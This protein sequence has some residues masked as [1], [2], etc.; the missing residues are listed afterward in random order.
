MQSLIKALGSSPRFS[1]IKEDG[2]HICIEESELCF[3]VDVVVFPYWP[4]Y[5]KCMA[6]FP[7]PCFDVLLCTPCL[8]DNAAKIGK[9]VNIFY[10]VSFYADALC[11]ACVDP[12]AFCFLDVYFKTC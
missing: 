9:M 2:L 5:S 11:V 1:T 7:Y 8:A 12:E 6:S 3:Q 4:Q 10:G